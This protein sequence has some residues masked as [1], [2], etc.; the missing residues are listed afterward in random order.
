[1]PIFDGLQ[2]AA[3]AQ[4]QKLNLKRNENNLRNIEQVVNYQLQ[5][6]ALGFAN[7]AR[8][9]KVQQQN[10]ALAEEILRDVKVRYENVFAT[11]QEVI[12]AEN[13]LKDAEVLYFTALY[14]YLVAEVDWK[15][16]NGKM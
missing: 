12:D 9:V 16:A 7:A 13:I 2:K 11:Y 1:M 8:N 10:I 3:L 14:D 6:S 4:Q 15:K 5:S